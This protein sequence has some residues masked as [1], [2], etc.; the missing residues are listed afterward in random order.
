MNNR[1]IFNN[2]LEMDCFCLDIAEAW[3]KYRKDNDLNISYYEFEDWIV[4]ELNPALAYNFDD[5]YEA[6]FGHSEYEDY[7]EDE[8]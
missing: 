5:V 2:S 8:D 7:D 4:N 1:N 3:V 6:E